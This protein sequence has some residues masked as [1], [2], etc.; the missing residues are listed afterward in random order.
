M[1]YGPKSYRTPGLDSYLQPDDD[2]AYR[3]AL[4]EMTVSIDSDPRHVVNLMYD[5]DARDYDGLVEVVV[6]AQNLISRLGGVVLDRDAMNA[7]LALQSGLVRDGFN[8]LRENVVEK[9][10]RKR[11]DELADRAYMNRLRRR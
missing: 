8:R 6:L 9:A 10:A 5:A 7:M 3:E 4:D 11:A 1:T 2:S